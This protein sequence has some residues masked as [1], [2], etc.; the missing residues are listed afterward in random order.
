M[1]ISWNGRKIKT[2]TGEDDEIHTLR[3]PLTAV[4]GKN[5]LE[6][7]GEGTSDS[8]G[9]TING[10]QLSRNFEASQFFKKPNN[11]KDRFNL[12]KNGDFSKN[13]IGSEHWAIGTSLPGWEVFPEVEVGYGTVYNNNWGDRIVVELDS[14]QN[15]VLKQVFDLECQEYT[16]QL[17]YAA[18][19]G[20]I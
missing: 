19:T 8:Y 3:V 17:D 13:F 4:E 10:V 15:D 7:A 5:T 9:M 1:C 11:I 16:L 6:I 12:V 18:R 14:N 20:H 2:I